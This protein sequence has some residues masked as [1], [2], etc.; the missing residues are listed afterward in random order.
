M[1]GD[2]LNFETQYERG[3]CQ[4]GDEHLALDWDEDK[5]SFTA[6]CGC[7]KRHEV[8]PITCVVEVVEE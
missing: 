7:M 6:E 4:C 8:K 5:L 2:E 1:S 3:T